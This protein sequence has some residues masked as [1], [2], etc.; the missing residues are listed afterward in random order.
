[1]IPAM[2]I[3]SLLVMPLVSAQVTY[4]KCDSK[5]YPF[6]NSAT[7][8]SAPIVQTA[9]VTKSN[10]PITI[11][12][13]VDVVDGCTFAVTNFRFL[14]AGETY[15]YGAKKGATDGI[16]L[17]EDFVYSGDVASNR[18]YKFRTTA[19]AEASYYDFSQFR[20]FEKYTNTLIAVADLPDPPANAPSQGAPSST[21]APRTQ[22]GVVASTGERRTS[23]TAF[24]SV[25]FGAACFLFLAQNA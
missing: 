19:G 17:T 23:A 7:K 3:S 5:V 10:S 1:M 24:A 22:S 25:I 14:G 15:W 12:G 2:F 8:V 16:L 6:A 21:G 11:S 20:L 4:T 13:S 18:T 9:S